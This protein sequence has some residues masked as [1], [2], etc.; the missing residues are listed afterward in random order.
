[1][2]VETAMHKDGHFVL[3]LSLILLSA[4]MV[5]WISTSVTRVLF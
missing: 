2:M 4:I 5:A 3:A 1:M